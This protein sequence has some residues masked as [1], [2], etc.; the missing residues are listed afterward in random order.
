MKRKILL[1][2][3]K[4]LIDKYRTCGSTGSNMYDLQYLLEKN[5]YKRI[6][7]SKINL[8][9]YKEILIYY[10]NDLVKFISYGNQG[11]CDSPEKYI[12]THLRKNKLNTL[13][14]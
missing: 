7:N 10:Y 11:I 9:T 8:N 3:N 14:K 6:D 2:Y 13:L 12:K 4:Y 1:G 5:G